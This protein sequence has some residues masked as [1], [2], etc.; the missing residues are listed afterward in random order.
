MLRVK[1]LSVSFSDMQILKDINFQLDDGDWL[2]IL[3]PNGSGK[4]TIT[5]AI[6][7]SIEYTGDITIQG[8]EVH[9]LNALERAKKIG[10]LMQNH[11]VAYGYTVH[12]IVRL[13]AYARSKGFLSQANEDENTRID[14]ALDDTGMESMRDRSVLTLSGGELQRTFLAQLLVQDPSI[15]IL[16]EPTNH[17][18]LIYQESIFDLID[19]WRRQSSKSVL[20]VVHDLRIARLYG[21]KA[22]L[23]KNGEVYAHG[24]MEAVMT[25]ENLKAVYG[26]DVYAWMNNLNEKWSSSHKN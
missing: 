24:E 26:M 20:S 21:N 16:D 2:M 4:T 9:T 11:Y 8:Q 12:D 18:D 22:L 13:G 7:Q 17:L 1:N 3:G 10:V 6:A 25:P 14:K 19:Q 15:M 23:L 5:N